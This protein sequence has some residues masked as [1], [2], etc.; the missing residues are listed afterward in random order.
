MRCDML[1]LAKFESNFSK[2]NCKFSCESKMMAE[3]FHGHCH[4]EKGWGCEL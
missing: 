2:T 3:A 1:A 4:I